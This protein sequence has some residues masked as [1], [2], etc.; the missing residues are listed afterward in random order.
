MPQ[1]AP[2]SINNGSVAVSYTPVL[3]SPTQATFE[4]QSAAVSSGYGTIDLAL[5]RATSKRPTRHINVE[6]ALPLVH[7][8][9]T[10]VPSRYTVQGV[11]RFKGHYIVPAEWTNAQALR[12]FHTVK[13]SLALTNISVAVEK[14]EGTY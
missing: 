7:E 1:A 11:G 6:I 12:L 2:L 14:G 10:M 3:A 5:S 9:T 4:D 8:D 13:N